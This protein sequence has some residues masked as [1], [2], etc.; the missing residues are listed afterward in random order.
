MSLN[1]SPVRKE[2]KKNPLLTPVPMTCLLFSHAFLHSWFGRYSG[3][4]KNEKEGI[5]NRIAT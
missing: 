5:M 4:E 1:T 3:E 2:R